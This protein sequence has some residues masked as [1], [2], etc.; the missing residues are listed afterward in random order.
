MFEFC[1]TNLFS[2]VAQ[3]HDLCLCFLSPKDL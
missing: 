3:Q 2:L 1:F